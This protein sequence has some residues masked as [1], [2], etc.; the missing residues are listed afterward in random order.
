[1]EIKLEYD[2][3]LFLLRHRVF[4]FHSIFSVFTQKTVE[5]LITDISDVRP[6]TR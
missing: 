3:V 5:L 6:E 1:M 2:S 4:Q